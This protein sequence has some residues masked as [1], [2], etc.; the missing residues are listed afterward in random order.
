M[1]KKEYF[2]KLYKQLSKTE[3][4][5]IDRFIFVSQLEGLKESIIETPFEDKL[6]FM[7]SLPIEEDQEITNEVFEQSKKSIKETL[8]DNDVM[9]I[10]DHEFVKSVFRYKT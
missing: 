1:N 3:K 9:R 4:D 8:S 10:V 5:K 6:E 2:E 7:L